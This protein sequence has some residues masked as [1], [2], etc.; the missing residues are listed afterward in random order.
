MS[1]I[2]IKPFNY[3]IG[4][5]DELNEINKRN[6][7]IYPTNKYA[8]PYLAPRLPEFHYDKNM[9]LNYL[10]GYNEEIIM[11]PMMTDEEAYNILEG[12]QF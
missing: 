8:E 7:F 6:I 12:M 2:Q 3:Y 1:I 9:D 4:K 10:F 11:E 5:D